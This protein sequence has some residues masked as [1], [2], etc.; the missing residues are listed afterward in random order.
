M[1]RAILYWTFVGLLGFSIL[2]RV[3]G[4][5]QKKKRLEAIGKRVGIAAALAFVCLLGS[6]LPDL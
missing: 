2:I 6:Y 1:I 3:I 4:E 5:L